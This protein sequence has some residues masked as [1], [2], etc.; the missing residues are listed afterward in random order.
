MEKTNDLGY[1]Q[2]EFTEIEETTNSLSWK[3]R[4]PGDYII[5]KYIGTE[6]G[7]GR[8]AGLIFY[9]LQDTFEQDVSIL[10]STVLNKKLEHIE[11]GS[12]IKIEYKGKDTAKNGREYNNFAVYVAKQ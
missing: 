6:Q 12:I 7:K 10:G 4:E 9:H 1:E 11:P 5:G 3:P 8:G 2:L